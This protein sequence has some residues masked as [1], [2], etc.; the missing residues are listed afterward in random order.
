MAAAAAAALAEARTRRVGLGEVRG[1]ERW[2]E[3]REEGRDCGWERGR[4]E[5][6]GGRGDEVLLRVGDDAVKEGIAWATDMG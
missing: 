1:W 2:Q 5:L 4:N 3:G 6:V